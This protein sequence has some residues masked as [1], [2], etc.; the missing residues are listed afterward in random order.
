MNKLLKKISL[1]LFAVWGS[2]VFTSS[3]AWAKLFDMEEFYL[4]NGLQVIVIPNEKAPVVQH[5][6]W[7]KAGSVDEKLGK[8]GTAHLLEHLMFRGTEDVKDGEFN[9]IIQDNGASFNAFTSQDFTAYHEFVD[10]SRLELAMFLEADRMK[11]F[12]I[13]PQNFK[14]ERNIVYQERKEVVENQPTAYF[15]ETL[16]RNLWQ[17]HPY[18]RP[19]TGSAEEIL[20]LQQQDVVDFYKNYYAPNNAVLILSGAIDYATARDLAQKYY[21]D[22]E[23]SEVAPKT[24]FPVLDKFSQ[25]SFEMKLPQIN[26][27]R[28]VRRFLV[29][30]FQQ[31]KNLAFAYD[32][33]AKYLGGGETSELYKKLVLEDEEALSVSASYDMA[34][35]SYGTFTLTAVP[36]KGVNS[37]EFAQKVNEALND[38]LRQLNNEKLK[39][40]KNRILAGLIYLKDDP[41]DAGNIVGSL[42]AAGM[43]VEDIQNY[44]AGINNVNLSDVKKAAK[45]LLQSINVQGILSPETGDL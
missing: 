30:S 33:L 15:S 16:A 3:S 23:K 17:E 44:D 36:K 32:V 13:T 9:Q 6:V 21:G 24:D 29:P 43:S 7:Y 37:H 20:S 5:M 22:I 12:Q 41:R 26:S 34:A 19:I 45:L 8:G 31:D 11:N 4:D 27:K 35:R 2:G 28:F 1:S 10:I 39:A 18:A 38:A 42:A 25:T 14:K 40:A